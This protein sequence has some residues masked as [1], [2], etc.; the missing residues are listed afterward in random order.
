MALNDFSFYDENSNC[1]ASK[2]DYF[3]VE[4][5]LNHTAKIAHFRT[6]RI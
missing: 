6:L 4:H 3:L 2:W 1:S 5:N